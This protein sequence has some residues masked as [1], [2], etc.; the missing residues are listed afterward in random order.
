MV[1]LLSGVEAAH[2]AFAVAVTMRATALTLSAT[3]RRGF[4]Q[5]QCQ[6]LNL[7]F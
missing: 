2:H 4:V 5:A 7:I 6:R 1:V 3:L